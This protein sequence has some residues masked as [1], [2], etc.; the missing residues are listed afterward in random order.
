MKKFQIKVEKMRSIFKCNKYPFNIT[1][2]RI[3]TFLP[4]VPK[5]EL[6]NALLY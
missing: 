4:A 1:E 5:K 3:E 6:L 2:Q